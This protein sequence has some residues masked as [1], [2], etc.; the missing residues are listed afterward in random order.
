MEQNAKSLHVLV[1][2]FE[3]I[4]KFGICHDYK[5][6]VVEK[7]FFLHKILSQSASVSTFKS[8]LVQCLDSI[9]SRTYL[10]K[11]GPMLGFHSFQ[12]LLM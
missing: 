6:N 5:Q 4:R 7:F 3:M 8:N 11:F 9:Y 10:C 1:S 2:I 12:N